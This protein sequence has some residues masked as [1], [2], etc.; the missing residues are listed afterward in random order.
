MPKYLILLIFLF[1]GH[2]SA[3]NLR[4][5]VFDEHELHLKYSRSYS[6]AWQI[7]Q[8]AANNADIQLIPYNEVWIRSISF[9]KQHKGVNVVFGAMPSEQRKAWTTFSAPLAV[10]HI[11]AYAKHDSPYSSFSALKS[12]KH[13][14]N[15]GVTRGS[16]HQDLAKEFGFKY[17]HAFT[18]RNKVFEMLD[19]GKVDALIYTH[20]LTS[21]YCGKFKNVKNNQCLKQL[22][23]PIQ[24]STLHFMFNISD[25]TTALAVEKIQ[26]QIKP[27]V[28]GNILQKLFKETGYTSDDYLFWQTKYKQWLI[29]K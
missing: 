8:M 5:N 29:E 24:N 10:E 7:F 20:A 15:L 14:V 28:E 2:L 12:N 25:Q 1:S 13:I 9:L 18:D 22:D 26:H 3:Q 27:L 16:I 23:K 4:V 11:A 19:A 6:V 17:I 21:F